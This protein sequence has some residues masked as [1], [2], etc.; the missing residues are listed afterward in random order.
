MRR[1][2]Q[3]SPLRFCSPAT[4]GNLFTF[5]GEC[6]K[7]LTIRTRHGEPARRRW[8]RYGPPIVWAILIFI[9]SSDLLSGSHT[10]SFL[11]GPL[12]RL[13]PQ[14]S[15]T[16]LALIHLLIRK[17][18]HLTEYAILAWLLARAFR[19]STVEFLRRRWFW[20][21]LTLVVV[22]SLSDEF[23]QSFVPT[24]GASFHDSLIDSA[25]GLLALLMVWWWHRR[26]ERAIRP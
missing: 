2:S 18:G 3:I 23:H 1:E 26:S 8:W 24:R 5:D 17:A 11:L 14:A 7:E 15:E 10:G 25:G 6:L 16:T 12:R 4:W 13:F 20:S 9:G 22:Y 21:A 19:T